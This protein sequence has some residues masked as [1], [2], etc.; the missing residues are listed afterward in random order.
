MS[1]QLDLAFACPGHVSMS[2]FILVL[3]LRIV[4]VVVLI[5]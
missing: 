3:S 5:V 2:H 1:S 4:A